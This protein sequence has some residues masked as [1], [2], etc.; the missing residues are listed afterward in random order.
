MNL[1]WWGSSFH[2][3]IQTMGLEEGPVSG[4][5]RTGGVSGAQERSQGWT[6]S[7]AQI[8]DVSYSDPNHASTRGV[9]V[10]M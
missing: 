3:A 4:G 6:E 5:V 8:L 2:F 10:A 7:F 9:Q 1:S